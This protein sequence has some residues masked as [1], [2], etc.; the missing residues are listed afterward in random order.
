MRKSD[1]AYPA[2]GRVGLRRLLRPRLVPLSHLF[3][4]GIWDGGPA[5]LRTRLWDEKRD[6]LGHLGTLRLER[7]GVAGCS[8][9]PLPI[10]EVG[11]PKPQNI[12]LA[13]DCLRLY[14]FSRNTYG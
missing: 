5:A 3:I 2:L 7:P 6:T 14:R 10:F 1:L 8:Q 13:I 9:A 12:R 4:N 11:N